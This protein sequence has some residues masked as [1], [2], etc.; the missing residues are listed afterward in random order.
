MTSP[1]SQ[2]ERNNGF[3]KVTSEARSLSSDLK[4]RRSSGTTDRTLLQLD[5]SNDLH[6]T[7]SMETISQQRN[8]RGRSNSRELLR[9]SKLDIPFVANPLARRLSMQVKDG[10]QDCPPSPNRSPRV[11]NACPPFVTTATKS[12][13]LTL[14][15]SLQAA[16]NT[17]RKSFNTMTD[18][19]VSPL[20]E[21]FENSNF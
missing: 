13:F 17:R 15:T 2:Q 7:T 9:A 20:T 8:Q 19:V 5:T 12:Q 1:T 14:N 3:V 4:E 21:F 11:N 16:L 10:V 6:H 18:A